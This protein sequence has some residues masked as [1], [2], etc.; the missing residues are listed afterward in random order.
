MK[1]TSLFASAAIL[2]AAGQA[3]AAPNVV[4]SIKPI[5][6][7]AAALMEGIGKPGIIVDGASSP[8]AFS[9]KP[10]DAEKLQKADVIFWVGP[11]LEAFLEKPLSSLAGN[12]TVTQLD[13]AKGLIK[14]QPREGG[15]FEAD[16][17]GD[18]DGAYDP[19]LWLDPENAK[20]IARD[21]AATLEKADPE[22]A[23]KYRANEAKLEKRLGELDAQ[24]TTIVAPIKDKPFIVFHDAYHYFEKR[25]GVN[26]AGS[27]TVSPETAP[28]AARIK[29][30]QDKIASLNATCVFAEPEFEPKLVSVVM[31]GTNAK[32]S[33]LDPLG[34]AIP[35]G[36]DLY[37]TL[38]HNLATSLNDCL[39]GQS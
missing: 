3:A 22:N 1:L 11:T 30:I 24:I 26:E 34:A 7:L 32:A 31:E 16:D 4:V 13:E 35:D 5:H 23:A 19:H 33:T 36:P 2:F 39:G 20:A 27:I 21:M 9:L 8:H 6:S 15:T 14:L 12:A 38:L 29:E 28:G 10:S 18:D 17:D 37:F 25:Y